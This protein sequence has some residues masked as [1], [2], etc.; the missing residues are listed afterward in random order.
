MTFH[1]PRD[2]RKF[3]LPLFVLL[4]GTLGVMAQSTADLAL[5]QPTV[6]SSVL[7]GNTAGRAVDNDANTRWESVH[8]SDP[9]WIY[10]DLGED[11]TINRVKL[12]WEAAYATEYRIDVSTN[13]SDWTTVTTQTNPP[14]QGDRLV[15]DLTGLTASGRYVRMFGTARAT[16]YGYSL[17][18]FAVYGTQGAK[19]ITSPAGGATYSAPAAVDVAI[20]G[21]AAGTDVEQIE[22]LMDDVV[23]DTRTAGP[24]A[25][26][27]PLTDLPARTYRLSARVTHTDGSV[28]N[29]AVV[30]LYVV[31]ATTGAYSCGEPVTLA[32]AGAPEGGSYR[33]YTVPLGGEAIAGESAATYMTPPVD[34][35]TTYYVSA[36]DA[37]GVESQRAPV[38]ASSNSLVQI[39]TTGLTSSYPFHGNAEDATGQ[40]NTGIVSGATLVPDRFGTADEAYAFDGVDDYIATT[41][42]FPTDI[43]GTNIFSLSLW[44]NTT[45]TAG[46]K[47]LGLGSRQTGASVQY[48]RHIYMNDAGQVF[49]GIYIDTHRTIKTEDAYNDG[50]WHNA[51]AILA[52]T[53]IK[54]YIDGT[55]QAED[56]TVTEGEKYP[57]PG[58][59]RIGYDNLTGWP[60]KPTDDHFEGLLDDIHIY[61][62]TEIT[63]SDLTSLYGASVDP[64]NVGETIELN[65]TYLDNV[66]YAWTGPNGFTSSEQNPRIPNATSDNAGNYTVTASNGSCISAPVTVAAI[67]NGEFTLPVTLVSLT[68]RATTGSVQLGW[69]TDSERD[70]RGF[71]VQRSTDGRH[72]RRIGYV[73][74]A[75]DSRRTRNY[76]YTDAAA[77]SATL[78]YRLLSED[79]SGHTTPSNVVRA[80]PTS[81]FVARVFPNPATA[82]ASLQ[83]SGAGE[84]EV[85]LVLADAA[86]RQLLRNQLPGQGTCILPLDGYVPGLY[87]L[88]LLREGH[89]VCRVRVVKQ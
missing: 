20:D 50:A 52:P 60:E 22:L 28:T 71:V 70:N 24:F 85:S 39:P 32:A 7:G 54:L 42:A 87:L 51:V 4:I 18:E 41:T 2:L 46:G 82:Q 63:P 83:Y 68:A 17:F 12:I 58:Y 14:M 43:E 77:A 8:G 45:T 59:W 72:F 19:V 38:T 15:N 80:T 49:F 75:G 16:E 25:Y 76:A 89:V 65:A 40:G 73:A 37:A 36:V 64:V 11:Y 27:V 79:Y 57:T 10:V 48:D 69:S 35:T 62:S 84:G 86:G 23:V 78:Y 61:Y 33:W 29:S 21:A 6:A 55:L 81:D 30:P 31:P 44:F 47:L 26:S 56:A 74:G 67:V 9:Q 34:F 5:N 1:H 13:G 88:T 66:S 3:A 53:G